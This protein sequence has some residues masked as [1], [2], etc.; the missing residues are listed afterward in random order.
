MHIVFMCMY[1]CFIL[2]VGVYMQVSEVGHLVGLPVLEDL[3]LLGNP[4][5]QSHSY[6]SNVFSHLPSSADKVCAICVDTCLI[7]LKCVFVGTYILYT[8]HVMDTFI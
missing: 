3:I 4:I 6:R 2:C 1:E 5:K 8:Q 7:Y